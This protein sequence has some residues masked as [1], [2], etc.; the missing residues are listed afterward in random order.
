MDVLHIAF[1]LYHP[2]DVL[3]M[4]LSEARCLGEEANRKSNDH[5]DRG[6]VSHRKRLSP[7]RNCEYLPAV[8]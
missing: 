5:Q 2:G 4:F 8:R 3:L 7:E 6:F 1:N